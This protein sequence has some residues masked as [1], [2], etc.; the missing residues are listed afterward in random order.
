MR[1]FLI[2]ILALAVAGAMG[3]APGPWIRTDY[4][5]SYDFSKLVTYRWAKPKPE[6]PAETMPGPKVSRMVREA[7]DRELQAKGYRLVPEGEAADFLV[8]CALSVEQK[9][10]V[11]TIRT[12]YGYGRAWRHAGVRVA[13]E[14]ETIVQAYY[15]EGT[16]LLDVVDA[17]SQEA[18]WR[19]TA[20]SR[21]DR[22]AVDEKV[23]ARVQ[24]AVARILEKFP[25]R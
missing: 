6:A 17:R 15:E 19:G 11:R 25:P 8:A 4:A 23:R 9:L 18:V 2:G 21:V 1:D 14:P 7:V 24:D 12:T 13:Y 16:L 20:Q 10:D 3:C 5:E 22:I